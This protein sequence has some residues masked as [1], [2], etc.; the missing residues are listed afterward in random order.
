MTEIGNVFNGMRLPAIPLAIEN[1]L[2][3]REEKQRKEAERNPP[4]HDR[5]SSSG[6]CYR[7][8]WATTRGVP[9]DAGKGFSGSILKVFRLG[10]IIE[11]EVVDLLHLIPGV[12]VT[13]QQM[14]LR[15]GNWVGHIDGIIEWSS[16]GS[17]IR[18]KSLL[19]I[20]S[21]KSSRFDLLEKLGYE[22]WNPGYAD[23]LQAYMAHIEEV[24]D[25]VVVVYDKDTSRIH[26][27][28]IL[29]D[30]DRADSLRY[31]SLLVTESDSVPPRPSGATSQSCKFCRWC[32]RAEWCWS[33]AT[34]V[35]FDK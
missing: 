20:K 5:M 33:A 18:T 35:E 6:R 9:L 13:D 14:Q 27:E 25:A 1:A 3:E 21:A 29:E 30:P 24:S 8:R 34:N 16:P 19:E 17:A 2:L 15:T 23:Q 26:A 4:V 22:A 12:R 7:E 32:D 10:H 28:R 11:D 31:E